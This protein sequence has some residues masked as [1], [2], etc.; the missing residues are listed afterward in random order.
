MDEHKFKMASGVLPQ[1]ADNSD[2]GFVIPLFCKWR[3]L[4]WF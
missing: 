3:T 1:Q 2:T 4:L